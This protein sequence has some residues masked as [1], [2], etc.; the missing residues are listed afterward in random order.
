MCVPESALYYYELEL[1]QEY[2]AHEH[3]YDSYEEYYEAMQDD[4]GNRDYDSWKDEQ[5]TD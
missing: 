1:E 5:L 4:K 3:G 2:E